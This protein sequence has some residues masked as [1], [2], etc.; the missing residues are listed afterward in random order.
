M[1]R[2]QQNPPSRDVVAISPVPAGV[3]LLALSGMVRYQGSSEHKRDPSAGPPNPKP[4]NRICPGEFGVPDADTGA[5]WSLL[6]RW[7]RD[8][9]SRG[10]CGQWETAVLAGKGGVALVP[11]YVWYK[12][13]PGTWCVFRHTLQ[14]I[15]KGYPE[16]RPVQIPEELR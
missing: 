12:V 16:D 15:Y 4:N 13:E 6:T 3:D 5:K 10:H 7:L 2:P 11:R 9:V 1:K 8:A 14:A